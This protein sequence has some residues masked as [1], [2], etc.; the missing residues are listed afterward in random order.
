MTHLPNGV[1]TPYR[2]I[3]GKF[4]LGWPKLRESIINHMQEATTR[5]HR[6]I[7]LCTYH[8]SDGCHERGCRGMNF[9][10]D[11]ARESAEHLANQYRLVFEGGTRAAVFPI[12]V[13]IETDR[14]GFVIHGH[15]STL[16]LTNQSIVFPVGRQDL[17]TWDFA[18]ETVD[19]DALRRAVYEMFRGVDSQLVE[20]LLPVLSGN[21]KHVFL[22]QQHHVPIVSLDH[23]ET[24]I[25]VG[26]GFDWL[27][28]PNR[29]LVV[30]PFDDTWSS[31]VAT[32]ANVVANNVHTEVVTLSDGIVLIAS[33]YCRA[34]PGSWQWKMSEMTSRYVARV[35]QQ[36]LLRGPLLQ[37]AKVVYVLVGVVE[38]S[39]L[40]FHWLE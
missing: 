20:D 15:Q 35:S 17:R 12:V 34:P 40:K 23:Q 14:E 22:R 10:T 8:F 4:D 36:A 31:A 19:E 38:K 30:G 26:V 33:S 27:H 2:N 9:D 13:G 7:A 24:V 21:A 28:V 11:A 3:A 16:P 1:I 39:T 37:E 6:V 25:A 18:C 5:G 32:A 29:A